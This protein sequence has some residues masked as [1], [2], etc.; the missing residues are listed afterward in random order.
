MSEEVKIFDGCVNKATCK[1]LMR[2]IDAQKML[3]QSFQMES[4]LTDEIINR[5]C[6]RLKLDRLSVSQP[7]FRKMSLNAGHLIVHQDTPRSDFKTV[8]LYLNTRD[9]VVLHIYTR[10]NSRADDI[11]IPSQRGRVVVFPSAMW[12]WLSNGPTTK[13]KE[14]YSIMF[15]VKTST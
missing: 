8:L 2:D 12:H 3:I 4:A 13:T 1:R 10:L 6:D 11:H 14:R 7:H 15:F 5:L 9:S